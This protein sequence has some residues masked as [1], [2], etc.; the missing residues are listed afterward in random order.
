MFVIISACPTNNTGRAASSAPSLVTGVRRRIAPT[1]R[2]VNNSSLYRDRMSISASALR[3][4]A[5]VRPRLKT[6]D[7]RP[8]GLRIFK[9][10]ARQKFARAPALHSLDARL[11]V[12]LRVGASRMHSS[13]SGLVFQ[14]V[15]SL[16]RQ[17]SHAVQSF[18]RG[19]NVDN[20]SSPATQLMQESD[21]PFSEAFGKAVDL[22][23]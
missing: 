6:Y 4:S 9:A 13:V 20:S 17:G 11:A 8:A 7:S 22:G 3:S 19:Y 16:N 23:N 15:A 18:P 21:N 5:I 10:R 14:P 1:F 2:S 12:T